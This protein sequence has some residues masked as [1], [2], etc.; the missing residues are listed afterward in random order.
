M[1]DTEL[2][3]VGAGFS[4]TML[5]IN[6][7]RLGVGDVTLVDEP[8]S[9]GRGLAYAR[10]ASHHLLNVR[11]GRMSAHPDDPGHFT[12]WLAA[13]G[14]ADDEGFASR[15]IYGD[16]LRATL[17]ATA[18]K[19]GD[20]LRIVNARAVSA[21][22]TAGRWSVSL[23]DGGRITATKLVL[24]L[25]NLPPD[26]PFPF[27]D[28]DLSVGVYCNDPWNA[29]I[30]DGLRLQDT[31]V[32]LGTGLTMIDTA[33][34][35]KQSGFGGRIV[36]ISRRGLLPR[37]HAAGAAHAQGMEGFDALPLSRRVQHLRRRADEIGWRDAVDE[38]RPIT[39]PLW[40]DSAFETR[41]RFL[42]HLRPWWDVHR[43]RVAPSIEARV[44]HL[45]SEGGLE[46]IAA[47]TMSAV[48][49]DDGARITYRCRGANETTDL[50]ARRIVNCTGPSGDIGRSNDPLLRHLL[51][52]GVVRADAHRLGI[53]VDD[54]QG[55]V[56]RDGIA[57][58]DL[59]AVGPIARGNIWEMT[60]V[61]DLRSQAAA[62]ARV[63]A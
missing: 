26:A 9:I 43:H 6:H 2:L 53:E 49:D 35:L 39:Q 3:V 50:T 61:P 42:R 23:T 59:W 48:R 27:A 29:A 36:A 41:D 44:E 32:L 17:D 19:V 21:Y 4:G 16:Y 25:G 57:W 13:R 20:R 31:V 38:L 55:V 5:A 63:V 12:N 60:A 51:A 18:A 24:A 8:D 56:A 7:L 30:V 34:L 33:L 14:I 10:S 1:S 37:A 45:R 22:R 11:S 28:A 54:R 58:S 46:V 52:N 47:K 40:R 15:R 62:M